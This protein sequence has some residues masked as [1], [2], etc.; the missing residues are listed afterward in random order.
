MLPAMTSQHAPTSADDPR[1]C[2]GFCGA[3]RADVQA[4][5]PGPTHPLSGALMAAICDGCVEIALEVVMKSLTERA[6]EEA[7]ALSSRITRLLG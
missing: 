1:L 3:G 7:R 2:C 5:V 4:I 6:P